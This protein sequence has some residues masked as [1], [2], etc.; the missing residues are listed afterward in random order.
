MADSM[1][2]M[3][4]QFQAFASRWWYIA[5]HPLQSLADWWTPRVRPE[6]YR[7]Q[8]IIDTEG[9]VTTLSRGQPVGQQPARQ[10]EHGGEDDTRLFYDMSGPQYDIWQR[11]G[12]EAA[13]VERTIRDDLLRAGETEPIT[14]LTPYADMAFHVDLGTPQAQQEALRAWEQER[15]RDDER[16][17][18]PAD[19]FWISK[20][21]M[22]PA[23][24]DDWRRGGEEAN[25]V[26]LRIW[27]ALQ[28][29]GE[30]GRVDVLTP[31]GDTAFRLDLRTEPAATPEPPRSLRE[32][33]KD[34]HDRLDAS[35]PSPQQTQQ[36]GQERG[37]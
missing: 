3:A 6:A 34:L 18:D 13:S 30:T 2:H 29:G 21:V 33:V 24:H 35:Q 19:P 22:T 9:P 5:S 26:E 20:V 14:V 1:Q 15:E 16:F 32:Q 37:W 27:E 8:M 10:A 7:Q 11:G 4:A 12:E 23:E 36:R 31:S 25:E 17:L 28:Q